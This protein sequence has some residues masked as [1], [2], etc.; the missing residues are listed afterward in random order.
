MNTHTFAN[1]IA[2]SLLLAAGF[3][4]P[5][6]VSAQFS[7]LRQTTT[8]PTGPVTPPPVR[9][10]LNSAPGGTT[11][12]ENIAATSNLQPLVPVLIF[13]EEEQYR[14]MAQSD[15]SYRLESKADDSSVKYFYADNPPDTYGRRT[16]VTDA[17]VTGPG[18]AGLIYGYQQNPTRYF[19]FLLDANQTFRVLERSPDGFSE[20]INMSVDASDRYELKLIEKGSEVSVLLNGQNLLSIS[21]DRTGMGAVGLATIGA[22][23][24]EFQKF[25]VQTNHE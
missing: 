5:G 3:V 24:F 2:P 23:S 10:N 11:S 21:N 7:A 6:S 8:Q 4:L 9:A 12:P 17:R 25:E 19:L 14:G 18:S 20:M 22:G 13:G 15:G 1:W 16:I